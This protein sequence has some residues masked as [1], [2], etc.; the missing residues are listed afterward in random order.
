MTLVPSYGRDY[1]SAK[2]VREDFNAGKDFKIVSVG[3]NIGRQCSVRDLKGQTVTLRYAKLSK[4]IVVTV[5]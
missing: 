2:A 1:N 3:P 4:A 5:S